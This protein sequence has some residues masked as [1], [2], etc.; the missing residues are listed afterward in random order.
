MSRPAPT[1]ASAR[2]ASRLPDA[3]ILGPGKL[4]ARRCISYL[5]IELKAPFR[6][7]CGR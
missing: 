5:T 7:S 3:A 4:D 1:A 2:R 6:W